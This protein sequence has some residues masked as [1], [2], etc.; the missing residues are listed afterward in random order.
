MFKGPSLHR[1]S[2]CTVLIFPQT[3]RLIVRGFL[4]CEIPR[5][6]RLGSADC[7]APCPIGL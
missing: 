7:R 5:I 4:G 3:P 1:G 2:P 6:R